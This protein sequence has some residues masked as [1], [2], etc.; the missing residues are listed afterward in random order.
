MDSLCGGIKANEREVY[1][2][3]REVGTPHKEHRPEHLAPSLVLT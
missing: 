1:G 3:V 2:V